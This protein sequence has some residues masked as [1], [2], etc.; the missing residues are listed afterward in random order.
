MPKIIH[1]PNKC[2]G[3]GICQEMQPDV[4]RMSKANGRAVLLHATVKKGVQQL[5]I[6]SS[7][8]PLAEKVATACP[9]RIIKLL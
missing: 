9:A 7:M 2:I 4:W 5:V 8:T 3:C 1:Y 6:H